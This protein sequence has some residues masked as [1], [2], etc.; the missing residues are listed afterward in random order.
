MYRPFLFLKK[1]SFR[2]SNAF[3]S[4]TLMIPSSQAI[5]RHAGRRHGTG[6]I[7][8]SGARGSRA[9]PLRSTFTYQRH[10]ARLR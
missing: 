3:V 9:P 5:N 1:K 10:L 4:A 8:S 7:R 6:R 2:F